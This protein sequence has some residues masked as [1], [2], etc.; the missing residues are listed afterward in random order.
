[1]KLNIEFHGF[2]D[3]EDN[4]LEYIESDFGDMILNPKYNINNQLKNAQA[5][6]KQYVK[7]YI[8][9]KHQ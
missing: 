7:E 3:E 1:M 8:K 2:V 4:E 6:I 5:K 9:H